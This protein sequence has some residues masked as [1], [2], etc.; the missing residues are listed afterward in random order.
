[1]R[2]FIEV[3]VWFSIMLSWA[4]TPVRV[5]FDSAISLAACTSPWAARCARSRSVVK[6]P[7]ARLYWAWI[8]T[9]ASAASTASMSPSSI[10][11]E[12]SLVAAATLP[13]VRPTAAQS[14]A[15]SVSSALVWP[16]LFDSAVR[17]RSIGEPLNVI[18][19]SSPVT[20]SIPSPRSS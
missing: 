2:S 11:S 17:N 15:I 9:S 4:S 3:A 19:P 8:E 10:A 13:P 1:M 5:M 18:R 14:A 16:I 12:V 7:N 20:W 6:S